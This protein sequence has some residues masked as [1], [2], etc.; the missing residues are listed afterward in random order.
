MNTDRIPAFAGKTDRI[1]L[2]CLSW[3]LIEEA[4]CSNTSLKAHCAVKTALS[5]IAN[6]P[7]LPGK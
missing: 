4:H 1:K 7:K 3:S 2:K 6:W 5:F